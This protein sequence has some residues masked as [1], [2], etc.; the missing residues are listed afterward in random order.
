MAGFTPGGSVQVLGIALQET[1]LCSHWVSGQEKEK[2]PGRSSRRKRQAGLL[3][4]GLSS[5]QNWQG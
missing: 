2:I 1:W 4:P 5:S 3:S